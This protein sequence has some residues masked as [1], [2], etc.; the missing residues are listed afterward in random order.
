MVTAWPAASYHREMRSCR[1]CAAT[2]LVIS[3]FAFVAAP[4][5]AQEPGRAGHQGV[6]ATALGAHRAKATGRVA[7]PARVPLPPATSYVLVDVGTG[8]VLAGDNENLRVRPASLTKILT[9]LIAVTYLPPNA[10]VPGTAQSLDAY[11]NIV[12]I[13]KG[14]GWPLNEVLQALLVYSAN[15]AAYAI[16][17]RVSGSLKAFGPVMDEAARQI[18]MSD[19]PVFHDPAGLDG[20]EGVGGGNLVSARDLA[21]AGRDLLHVPK[22]ARIVR[23]E[24]TAF[25]DPTGTAHDLPSM[26]YAFLVS[27]PGAIGIKTGF[28]DRAGSCILAAA[29]RHG[30][31]MLA[32]VMNGYNPTQSAIDLL[33]QGFATP[34][35]AEPSSDRL[36]PFAL[37]SRLP[38]QHAPSRTSHRHTGTRSGQAPAPAAPRISPVGQGTVGRG[39]PAVPQ[40]SSH[41]HAVRLAAATA[42]TGLTAVVRSWLAQILLMLAGVAGLLALWELA[43]T[44]R[45]QRRARPVSSYGQRA[46]VIDS[47]SASSKRSHEIVDSYRRHERPSSLSGPAPGRR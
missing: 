12:G 37:P 40:V 11:P 21:I 32:V 36:P 18:G 15:D 27:Y 23:E 4:A 8:N 28:T 45:I 5:G 9:A 2:L 42:P 6:A 41:S 47:F 3:V 26:D 25:V 31:T 43:C 22:L 1:A 16:A 10:R 33:N 13:Q 44:N 7:R 19:D 29:T 20:S 30:R 14:V 17:Q 35:A 38:S 34:V 39:A 46:S 24:S